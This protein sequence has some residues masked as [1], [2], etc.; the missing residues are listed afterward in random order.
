MDDCQAA[1]QHAALRKLVILVNAYQLR[2]TDIESWIRGG[3]VSGRDRSQCQGMLSIYEHHLAQ[4]TKL[5]T[6]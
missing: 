4:S 2:I 5:K 3:F 1:R 6:L